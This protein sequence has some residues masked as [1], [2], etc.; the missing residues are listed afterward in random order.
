MNHYLSN[1]YSKKITG[2]ALDVLE[3]ESGSFQN[4]DSNNN[5]FNQ[6][7]SFNNIIISPHIA[8]WS[9][10]SEYKLSDVLANKILSTTL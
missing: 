10:E 8:G 1:I 5:E 3:Y 6:L 4:I 2:A 9:V 7:I